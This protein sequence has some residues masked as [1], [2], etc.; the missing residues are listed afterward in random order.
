MVLPIINP[1]L[2][3]ILV[4]LGFNPFLYQILVVIGLNPFLYQI[5]VVLGFN[6]FLYQIPVVMGFH[7]KACPP[8]PIIE[9]TPIVIKYPPTSSQINIVKAA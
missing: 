3:Q 1:F 5:P 4:V 6:P 9:V 8:L 2:Y 7:I